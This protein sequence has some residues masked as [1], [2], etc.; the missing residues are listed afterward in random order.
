MHKLLKLGV[1]LTSQACSMTQAYSLR[2][3][4]SHRN[5]GTESLLHEALSPMG[6]VGCFALRLL[7]SFFQL[8]LLFISPIWLC[9][10]KVKIED[11]LFQTSSELVASVQCTSQT[12]PPELA[13]QAPTFLTFSAL[14][15]PAAFLSIAMWIWNSTVLSVTGP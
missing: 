4:C 7:H 12:G 15:H 3:A 1:F 5:R 8:S 6:Y 13:Q 14:V 2:T 11:F 10:E 9:S